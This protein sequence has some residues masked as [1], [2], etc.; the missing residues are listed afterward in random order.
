MT[1]KQYFPPAISAELLASEEPRD[2]ELVRIVKLGERSFT[3]CCT[4]TGIDDPF[5]K[6]AAIIRILE[7]SYFRTPIYSRQST[8]QLLDAS[9]ADKARQ[10]Y[11]FVGS[12]S[13]LSDTLKVCTL[14]EAR[15]FLATVCHLSSE[16]LAELDKIFNI[17][18]FWEK[19]YEGE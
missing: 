10:L 11:K 8:K 14:D 7:P 18:N 12:S 17:Q 9:M 3:N 4:E 6:L 16:E 1:E 13:H 19:F 2:K 15:R 5:Q